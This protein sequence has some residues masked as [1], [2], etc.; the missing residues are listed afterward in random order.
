[1][2]YTRAEN[3]VTVGKISPEFFKMHIYMAFKSEDMQTINNNY[4]LLN[5]A[6]DR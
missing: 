6:S 5:I 4:S 1:M 2:S 3:W